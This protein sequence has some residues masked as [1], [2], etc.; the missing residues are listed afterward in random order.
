AQAT[1]GSEANAAFTLT[2][3]AWGHEGGND[4]KVDVKSTDKAN[5]ELKVAVDGKKITVNLGTDGSAKPNSTSAEVIEAINKAAGD[6]V[7]AAK[8]RNSDGK[9]I[10]QPQSGISL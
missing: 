7:S 8:Y 2:S 1:I 4:I 5:A 3:K 9:G 10:V 6:L